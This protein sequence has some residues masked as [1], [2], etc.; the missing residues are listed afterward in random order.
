MLKNRKWIIRSLMV[1]L[2]CLTL[3]QAC[4]M[5]YPVERPARVTVV[6][7]PELRAEGKRLTMLMCGSCHYDAKTKSLTGKQMKDAPGIVGKVFAANL[8][9]DPSTGIFHYSDQE[10]KVL[11]RTG[12]SRQGKLMP[13]MLRPNLADED[14]SAIITFLRSDDALVAPK[15]NTIGKTKYTPIGKFGISRTKP[16]RYTDQPVPKPAADTLALGKYLVDNLACYHC[17]SK[18]FLKL[19]Y[20]SPERSKGYMA[21]GNRLKGAD[22]KTIVTPNL[23]FHETGLKGWTENDLILLLRQG[24][25]RDKK[26][27]RPP[28]PILPEL[29][30]EEI[31]SMYKYLR[32]LPPVENDTQ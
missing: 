15:P 19:D 9:N 30:D 4:R 1:L 32:K 21:G 14:I 17:H 27:V 2:S 23:T 31:V 10:L 20:Q 12:I 3:L 8:T 28:M 5:N 18:S 6:R 25:T 13:Y 29:T 11:F 22:G 24:I 26:I 16:L 7:R